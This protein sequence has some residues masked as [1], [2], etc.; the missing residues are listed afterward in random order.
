MG[1]LYRGSVIPDAIYRG[2]T[3]VDAVYRGAAKVWPPP[4]PDMDATFP[5]GTYIRTIGAGYVAGDLEIIVFQG[6][7][8]L[9]WRL[10]A[11]ERAWAQA[12][13]RAGGVVT[14]YLAGGG[15]IE[16]EARV[17]FNTGFDGYFYYQLPGTDRVPLPLD[18]YEVIGATFAP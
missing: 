3:A 17:D 9:Y 6:T 15:T 11:P 12:T 5:E 13:I 10:T 7:P 18:S 16:T 2:A 4:P 14:F 1:T 8:V